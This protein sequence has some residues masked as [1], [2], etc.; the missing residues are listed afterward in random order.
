[1]ATKR[2]LET[3]KKKMAKRLAP[4]TAIDV[5]LSFSSP[6]SSNIDGATYDADS[7]EMVVHF[8]RGPSYVF[9]NI[10]APVWTGF[11]TSSSKGSYFS[12]LIR[13]LYTGVRQ[14][15]SRRA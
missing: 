13:P 10:P 9:A 8:R 7:R 3:G 6:E 15:V 1:M 14:D 4:E 11:V 5:P 12:T 2:T